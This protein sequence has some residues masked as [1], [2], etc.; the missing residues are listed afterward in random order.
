MA[1]E[2]AHR[3]RLR[4]TLDWLIFEGRF[5]PDFDAFVEQAG[6]RLL[7]DGAPV[8]RFRLSFRTLHPLVTAVT[9]IW[10]RDKAT[11]QHMEARHGMET[12]DAYVGSPMAQIAENAEPLRIRLDAALD[13]DAHYTLHDLKARGATDY[14]GC[15]L[16]FANEGVGIMVLNSDEVGGFR[17][18]EIT[19]FQT[20]AS[21]LAPIVEIERLKR[22]SDA[23]AEAYLGPRTGQRVLGGRITRGDVETIDAAIMI[24][25][26]RNWTGISAN[27][28]PED[29][30]AL[31]NRYFD[32]VSEAVEA[33]GGEILKFMGDGV[34]AIF[35]DVPGAADPCE[36]AI[37][38]ARAALIAG[39]E[40][41]LRFGF[42]LHVG[43]VLYGNIGSEARLDF[44]VLGGAVNVAARIEALCSKLDRPL[45]YSADFAARLANPGEIAAEEL[46]KGLAAPT[47][48]YGTAT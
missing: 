27:L 15:R 19:G 3:W 4:D 21:A 30:I 17:E 47:T 45:L 6:L 16:P 29:A 8:S 9:G 18:E 5:A 46:L 36:R 40:A 23:V 35:S 11:V 1:S 37:A 14:F 44:T 48:I 7:A 32:L 10:E 38:A 2:D 28:S 33:E 43:E 39:K 24:S 31:A 22:I 20:L 42:G 34:L 41:E 12:R 13:R 26:L 25:D